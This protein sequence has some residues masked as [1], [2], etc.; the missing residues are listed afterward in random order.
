MSLRHAQA[1]GR[2]TPKKQTSG[3]KNSYLVPHAAF[4]REAMK[5]M[6]SGT[7]NRGNYDDNEPFKSL[8]WPL[9]QFL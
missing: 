7:S 1:F 8:P 9:L 2:F 6:S 5:A 4:F 3:A